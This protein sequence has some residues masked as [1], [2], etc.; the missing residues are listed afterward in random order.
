MIALRPAT[1]DDL[2][3]VERWDEAPQVIACDPDR[4]AWDWPAELTREP[5][6]REQLIAELDGR[7]IGVVQIID[8]A[9]EESHYWGDCGPGLRAIDIWIGEEDCLGQGHG[10]E[11][12]R[13]ALARCFAPPEVTAV[14][15]DPLV[16]N[17]GARRFYERLG[18]VWEG[19]RRLGDSDCAVYRL[20][21]ARWATRSAG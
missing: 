12:M 15:I 9:L 21:R 3:L 1:L 14:I 16:T 2:A 8:P 17:T 18:F 20:E 5:S 13:L 4:D 7:P 19:D 6:W 10:G 11:M